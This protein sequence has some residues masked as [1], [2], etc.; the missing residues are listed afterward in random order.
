MPLKP[1]STTSF[2]LPSVAL[3]IP[4]LEIALWIGAKDISA[5]RKAA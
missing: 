3:D 5:L 4:G 2:E 1:L